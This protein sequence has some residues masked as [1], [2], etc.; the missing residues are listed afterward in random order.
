M[1][2]DEAEGLGRFD[3]SGECPS[4][5]AAVTQHPTGAP[6]WQG[7]F[8]PGPGRKKGQTRSIRIRIGAPVA[9]VKGLE[10]KQSPE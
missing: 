3:F 4:A 8:G 9:A 6:G 7:D 10:R 5:R 2:E 1:P